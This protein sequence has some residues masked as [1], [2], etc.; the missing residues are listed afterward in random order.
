M[1]PF[2]R[3]LSY[4]GRYRGRAVLALL[5]MGVVAFATVALLFLLQRVIDD[6]LG[7]GASKALPGMAPREAQ[8]APLLRWLDSGYDAGVR[9]AASAGL[10][11]RYAVP[12]L[13]LAALLVKNVFAYL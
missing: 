5:A 2:P 10:D 7:A 9:A 1:K 6:V 3:L 12:L 8:A 11:A 13:L 4:F